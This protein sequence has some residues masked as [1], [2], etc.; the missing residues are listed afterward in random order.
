[1][2]FDDVQFPT[3]ISRGASSKPRRITDVVTLRSGFEE[4]NTIW[5]NSRRTFDIGLGLRDLEDIYEVQEFWEGRR[6]PLRS[7][8]FKDWSDYKSVSPGSTIS[9][10]DQSM[11]QITENIYQLQKVYSA[12]TNPWTRVITKP[13]QNTV[14]IRDNTGSLTE[15]VDFIVDHLTGLV[16]FGFVPNNPTAGFEFDV[17]TRF[18]DDNVEINVELFNV[19]QMPAIIL[20]EVKSSYSLF[21][22]EQEENAL[23]NWLQAVDINTA[24]NTHWDST[25][26][27][28]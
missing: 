18:Q 20:L 13:V 10:T 4:R 28:L 2:A 25:W 17:E 24:V 1:M 23:W 5:A 14:V 7:F 21:D 22:S 27:T 19:G 3:T 15:N 8:R 16:Y 26:G 11:S 9:G 12:S 6:G